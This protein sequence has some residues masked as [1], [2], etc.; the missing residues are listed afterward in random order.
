[1]RPTSARP[2]AHQ[3][4][5]GATPTHLPT[6]PPARCARCAHL[7]KRRYAMC[8]THFLHFHH[9][10]ALRASGSDGMCSCRGGEAGRRAWRHELMVA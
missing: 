7:L 2:P 8:I 3:P 6:R 5:P 4:T 1:M 10:H 9:C